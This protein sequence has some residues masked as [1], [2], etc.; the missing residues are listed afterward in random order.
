LHEIRTFQGYT[1]S[2]NTIAF[3]PEG[4]F[5][6]SGS[7]DK[8]LKLWDVNSGREIRSFQGHFHHRQVSFVIEFADPFKLPNLCMTVNEGTKMPKGLIEKLARCQ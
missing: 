1:E 6:L 3:S 7:D 8:T 2:V 4:K 5:F